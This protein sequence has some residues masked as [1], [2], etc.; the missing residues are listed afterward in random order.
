MR[1][2]EKE[3]VDQAVGADRAR[4]RNYLRVLRQARD[5]VIRVEAMKL[6]LSVSAGHRGHMI[7]VRL[8]HHRGH[9]GAGVAN[10]KFVLGMLLPKRVEGVGLANR[11]AQQT[12]PARMCRR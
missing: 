11:S 9:R 12:A 6:A 3:F 10:S 5:E 7:D 4:D 1:E 2:A 8:G